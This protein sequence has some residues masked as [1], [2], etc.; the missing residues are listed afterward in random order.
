[1]GPYLDYESLTE[2]SLVTSNLVLEL[3]EE[4]LLLDR[5]ALEL[6]AIDPDRAEK[7]RE[8]RR[9][10]L[11]EAVAFDDRAERACLATQRVPVGWRQR[12]VDLDDVV[13]FEHRTREIHIGIGRHL[14]VGLD[15]T[16]VRAT[17]E[18]GHQQQAPHS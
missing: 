11:R 6:G 10:G 18:Q 14:R 12:D 1:M 15:L 4:S 13:R 9:R 2:Y 16:W 7:L 3:A 5:Y 17:G 8:R